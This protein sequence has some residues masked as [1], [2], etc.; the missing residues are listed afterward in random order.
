MNGTLFHELVEAGYRNLSAHFQEINDLNVF[1]VPDGDTGTNMKLT[2]QSG[3]QSIKETSEDIGEIAQQLATGMT[4]G[5]RG[6]SGVL[7]SRYFS[8]LA[9]GLEG[10]KEASVFDFALAMVSAYQVAYVAVSE[11]TEGTILTV[12]REGI[13]SIRST[14]DYKTIDFGSF[15]TMVVQAMKMSLDNTPNLLPIL[16]ESG[17]V[18]SGGKGLLTIFEGF[19]KYLTG[20]DLG[21]IDSHV[22]SGN[23]LPTYDFSLFNENSVLTY[24]Y[25]TEFLLQLQTSKIDVSKFN[26]QDFISFLEKHGNSL[27]CFQNGTIVKV[28]IHTKK[29]YEVIEYAQRFGEFLTFKMENMALQHNNVVEKK[30]QKQKTRKKYAIVSVAQGDGIIELFKNL[31]S[32]VVLNGGQTMNTSSAEFISAFETANAEDIIV[33]PDESNILMAAHQAAELYKNSHVMV[34]D[35]RTI[36]EGYAALSM[37]MGDEETAQDCFNSMK[38]AVEDLTSGFI[39]RSIRDTHADGIECKKDWY[40]AGINGKLVHCDEERLAALDALLERIPHIEDKELLTVFTGQ[41]VDEE[42]SKRIEEHLQKK[43]PNLEIG[44]IDGKQ[45]VYDILLGVN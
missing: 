14:I 3:L 6:N 42:N 32:D 17:V 31:G 20:Q 40:I 19:V 36:P 10:K 2:L 15:F 27:V 13:E 29:P 8:G 7:S 21:N 28:H 24:G 35:T 34:L 9:K 26:L 22:E 25:C 1:P 12:A 18:D 23:G 43:Y 4:F 16:K 39:S 38:G 33:L 5:A 45:D 11:P 44:M 30:A 37:I 41:M